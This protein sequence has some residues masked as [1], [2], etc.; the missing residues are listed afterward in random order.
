MEVIVIHTVYP[1]IAIRADIIPVIHELGP[2][3]VDRATEEL[4]AKS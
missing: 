1:E 3:Y 2:K 4:S